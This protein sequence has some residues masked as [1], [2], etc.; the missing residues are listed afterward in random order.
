M[1]LI[2]VGDSENVMSFKDVLCYDCLTKEDVSNV[3]ADMN[4]ETTFTPEE[5]DIIKHRLGKFDSMPDLEDL[6]WVVKEI[7]KERKRGNS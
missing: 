6:R 5:Y 3:L 2:C 7:L 4:I 1:V